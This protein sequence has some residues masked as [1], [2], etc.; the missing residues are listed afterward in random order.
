MRG[1]G[2]RERSRV[3]DRVRAVVRG[4]PNGR[5]PGERAVDLNDSLARRPARIRSVRWQP[6]RKATIGVAGAMVIAGAV[7]LSWMLAS[8]P[9]Q[10][11]VTQSAGARLSV[12]AKPGPAPTSDGATG[13]SSQAPG[14]TAST[15]ISPEPSAG[16][17]I[18]GP[19]SVV[20]YIDGKVRHPG[21]Y[22]F[23]P[24]ARIYDAVN[25]AGGLS[26]GAHLGS[27]NPAAKIADGQQILVDVPPGPGT[28]S[29][30]VEGGTGSGTGSAGEGA[31]VDLNSA[32]TDQLQTL[33]GVGPVLAQHILDWRTAHGTFTTV[34]QLQEVSGIGPAKFAALRGRV[35]I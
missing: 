17:G 19:P 35:S 4:E 6:G 20:V 21:I 23:A 25:A 9:Q 18:A 34:E 11:P 13:L 26:P 15:R 12:A 31:P 32:T 27:L 22:H 29:T 7:A 14:G 10:I 2:A 5:A 30:A 24:G 1:I 3:A 33:P 28:V 8:R 16:S